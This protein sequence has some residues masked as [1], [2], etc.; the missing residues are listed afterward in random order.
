MRENLTYGLKWQGMESWLQPWRHPL[1]LPEP[2]TLEQLEA[3]KQF[4]CSSSEV[5]SG[6][7]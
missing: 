4:V 1:T 5:S 2:L 7:V 3:S 6:L